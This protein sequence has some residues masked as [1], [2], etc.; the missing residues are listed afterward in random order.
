MNNILKR[1]GKRI[2][3]FYQRFLDDGISYRAASLAYTTLLAIVPLMIVVFT[4]LSAF[5][6]FT[7]VAEKIQQI[8]LN[9]FV[10]GSAQVISK[11]LNDFLTHVGKLSWLNLSFLF[12]VG[13]L[14]MYNIQCAFD[15]IWRSERHFRWSLS[16]LVYFLVLLLSPLVLGALVVLGVFVS[17][18]PWVENFITVSYIHKPLLS[19]FPFVLIF[20]TFTMINWALPSCKVRIAHAIF[21]GVMTTV[22]FEL[23][24]CGFAIYLAHFHTYRIL[25]GT[26]ATIPI[27]LVWLYVSWTI[28]LFGALVTHYIAMERSEPRAKATGNK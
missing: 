20:A 13:V 9:N 7:G 26:L 11:Q 17:K 12:V 14:M 21:G 5:P 25:Y 2:V 28:I 8:V 23:A 22:L 19:V 3:Y 24:K 16:F 6:F 15:A 27:F 4:V 18:L 1:T 10:A